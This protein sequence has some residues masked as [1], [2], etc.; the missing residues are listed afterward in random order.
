MNSTEHRRTRHFN[1][2]LVG[3]AAAA[4]TAAVVAI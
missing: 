4:L 1:I 2:M 3:L